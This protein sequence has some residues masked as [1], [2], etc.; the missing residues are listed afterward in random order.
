[1]S[2]RTALLALAVLPAALTAAS[3][4]NPEYRSPSTGA[5]YVSERDTGAVARLQTSLAANPRDSNLYVQLGVAQSAI[6]QYHEAIA[7]MTRG[8]QAWPNDAVL[9]RYR[10]HRY[11]SVRQFDSALA[12]LERGN[13]L[14]TTNY[15]IWYHLG[16][17]RYVRADFAGAA[18]AFTH[19]QRMAP[20]DDELAGSTDWL[21]MSSSRA[22][23]SS[24]AQAALGRLRPDMRARITTARAYLKRL[25]LYRGVAQP[26]GMLTSADTSDIQVATLSYGIGNWYLVRGD[27]VEAR[28]W[29]Q[30]AIESGGWPAFGFI[31]AEQEIRR[32]GGPPRPAPTLAP[33][34]APVAAPAAPAAA[35]RDTSK[36]AVRDTSK[37]AQ[38]RPTRR[39]HRP[40]TSPSPARR[41]ST[42]PPRP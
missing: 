1:M 10:G 35:A 36:A 38:R 21:W 18:D 22:G 33:S 17:V 23:R 34:A 20:N 14:D 5:T 30:R 3:A 6:R 16:V 26:A 9:Y 39:P 15:D 19:A 32:I 29:F 27:S 24:E 8:L 37:A 4:Q 42:A 2:R 40:A 31:A 25:D 12:D 13:R 11:I 41:P 28:R 7:T